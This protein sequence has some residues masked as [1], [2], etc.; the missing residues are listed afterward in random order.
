MDQGKLALLADKT[1]D[2]LVIIA[3][4]ALVIMAAIEIYKRGKAYRIKCLIA[5]EAKIIHLWCVEN[6]NRF[7]GSK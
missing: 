7:R 5:K 1:M 6:K 3:F 2:F 4:I